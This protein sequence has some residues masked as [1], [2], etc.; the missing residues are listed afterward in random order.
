MLHEDESSSYRMALAAALQARRESQKMSKSAL[1]LGAG[2]SIQSVAF[3]E[4]GVNSPSVSNYLRMCA[5]LGVRPDELLNEILGP[6][7]PQS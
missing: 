7:F 3:V 1:A 2:I 5:A 4:N 6:D